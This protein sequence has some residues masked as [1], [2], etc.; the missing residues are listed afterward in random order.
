M[1]YDDDTEREEDN[2]LASRDDIVHGKS[3]WERIVIYL[4]IYLYR[5]ADQLYE[6]EEC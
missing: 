3:N 2:L 6:V 1:N 4:F 5:N